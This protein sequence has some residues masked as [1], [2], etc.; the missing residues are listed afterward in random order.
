[1]VRHVGGD[2]DLVVDRERAAAHD[3]IE[4]LHR[5][6]DMGDLL[7]LRTPHGE[8]VVEAVLAAQ[9][10]GDV[11]DVIGWLEAE[12]VDVELQRLV[13]L[14]RADERVDDIGRRVEERRHLGPLLVVGEELER[15]ARGVLRREA[16]GAPGLLRLVEL[17]H[18]RARVLDALF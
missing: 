3:V 17:L 18:R 1:M 7:L 13:E 10:R 11:R 6:A 9:E 12:D 5:E 14:R 4:A 8:R 2:L 16:A 15:V